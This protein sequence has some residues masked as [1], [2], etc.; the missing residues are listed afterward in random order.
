MELFDDNEDQKRIAEDILKSAW[1]KPV[2]KNPET[3]RELFE[4]RAAQLNVSASTA[5]LE[6]L[7]IE[8]RAL[9]GIL[10]GTQKRVDFTSLSKLARFLNLSYA[11][12]IELYLYNLEGNYKQEIG[13]TDKGKFI[14]DNFDLA[15]LKKAKIIGSINDFDQIEQELVSFLGLK[16]ILDYSREKI[17]AAF[18]SGI[19][20]PKNTLTRDLWIWHASKQFELYENPF[21]YDQQ[22]LIDYLPKIRWHSMNVQKGLY[23]VIRSLY[24]LG[25]TVIF[26][27][28]MPTLHLRGATFAVHDKPCIVITDYK[29][30]YPTLWFALIHELFHVLFDWT[31]IRVNKYHLSDEEVDVYTVKKREEEANKFARKFLF[32]DEKME[33]VRMN[34]N[35][36]FFISAVAKK[37]QVHPS[38]I[39]VFN[40]FDRGKE[41]L[42]AWPRAIKKI[43][44]IRESLVPLYYYEWEERKPVEEVAKIRK[45]TIFNNLN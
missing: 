37:H 14:L 32:S 17:D 22:A 28:Y 4:K 24:C 13:L 6:I 11:Q 12:V 1:F 26:Q 2:S 44:S 31:E 18:S 39:Y 21:E 36:D 10:D 35:D 8:W 41:D 43:P 30:Y 3:L 38:I 33:S 7:N 20:E 25:V 42:K 23:E 19:I 40:A 34:L 27:P 9:N 16:N 45:R 15:N 29:G 5:A